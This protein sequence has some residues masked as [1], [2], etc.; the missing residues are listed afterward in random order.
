MSVPVKVNMFPNK[1]LNTIEF[2]VR[3]RERIKPVA[4]K[5]NVFPKEQIDYD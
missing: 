5:E 1:R 4:K 3:F 2:S